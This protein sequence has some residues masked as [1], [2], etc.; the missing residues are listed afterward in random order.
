MS[1]T[2]RPYS[3]ADR[4]AVRHICCETGFSGDPV[5]PL[6]SDRD[7]FADFFTRY[8]TDWEPESAIVADD[9]GQTVGYVL[10]CARFKRIK[11]VEPLLLFGVIVPKAAWR[12]LTGRYNK[13]DRK[14]IWWSCLKAAKET[15]PAPKGAAHFHINLLPD[16]RATGVGLKMVRQLCADL[17]TKGIPLVYGQIQTR[18]DRRSAKAIRYYGFEVLNKKP[19]SKFEDFHHDTVYVTTVIKHLN[20]TKKSKVNDK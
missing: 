7:V 6:F 5:D 14:F 20:P 19:V 13:Q 11:W 1:I 16:Y 4:K 12:L 3:P 10:G 8:Y 18:D 15:P 2:I 9:N 17:E